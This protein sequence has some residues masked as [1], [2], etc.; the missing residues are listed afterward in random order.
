VGMWMASKVPGVRDV[1]ALAQSA[2]RTVKGARDART[3]LDAAV[4]VT[5]AELTPAQVNLLA[6]ILGIGAASGG[7]VAGGATGR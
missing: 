7:V 5:D 1:A 3:A 2:A 6:R 4:P